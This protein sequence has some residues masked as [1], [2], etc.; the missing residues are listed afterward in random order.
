[1][2]FFV[3]II[4][5]LVVSLV[6]CKVQTLAPIKTNDS[7][8]RDTVIKTVTLKVV[9]PKVLAE[10]YFCNNENKLQAKEIKNW[11]H[12]FDSL[13]STNKI[14]KTETNTRYCFI[15]TKEYLPGAVLTKEKIVYKVHPITYIAFVF[16][17][18]CLIVLILMR[19]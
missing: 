5:S 15:K 7:I 3:F 2:R 17:I 10:L 18:F 4:V 11:Q 6:G 14:V 16:G 19:K 8:I 13:M 9:D 1:M 12:V